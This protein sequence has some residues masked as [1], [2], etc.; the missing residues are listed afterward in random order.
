M[1]SSGSGGFVAKN[2]TGPD[3]YTFSAP[4]LD[5]R[6]VSLGDFRGQ[7]VLIVN[8]ASACGFTP[9]YRDLEKLY[10]S[11]KGQGFVVLGFPCNQFGA[12]EPGTSEE[13]AAFCEHQ[14]A[15]TFPLFARLD[16]N[17]PLAHP[18][19]QFLKDKRRG[20]FGTKRIKWNFTKF[21]VSRNGVVAA[22]YAP[23]TLPKALAPQIE[24][25]LAE[26]S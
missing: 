23:A 12:Q 2:D 6:S 14:Y 18:L 10:H 1:T 8:T 17:G 5:G 20:I 4:L 16:V 9:Q 25:L 15:V 22:R 21:L 3:F 11:F 7:V 24:R 26:E 19:F 13:I